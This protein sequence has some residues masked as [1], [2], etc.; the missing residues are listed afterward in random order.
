[1]WV[2]KSRF[3]GFRVS[4]FWVS[5]LR[6]SGLSVAELR[7]TSDP[8]LLEPAQPYLSL[9]A[10]KS[11]HIDSQLDPLDPG[12]ALNA[13]AYTLHSSLHTKP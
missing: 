6:D 1:M 9:E 8:G 2:R 13:E 10:L 4:G 7:S 12:A 11:V 5:G 3:L